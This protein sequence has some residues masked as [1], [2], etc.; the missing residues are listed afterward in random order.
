MTPQPQ[1]PYPAPVQPP[2]P[3]GPPLILDGWER[4][5]IERL[6]DL[7]TRRRY[8]KLIVEFDG[9]RRRFGVWQPE[10]KME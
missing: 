3:A 6:R 1:R 2:A 9:E 4:R 7:R 8:C 10:T 5:L